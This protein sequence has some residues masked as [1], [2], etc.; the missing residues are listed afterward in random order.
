LGFLIA[1]ALDL[2]VAG[3]VL[4]AVIAAIRA[5]WGLYFR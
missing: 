4:A 3:V 1:V 5:A 2:I